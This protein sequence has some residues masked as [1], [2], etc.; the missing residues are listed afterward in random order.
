MKLD[1]NL[2]NDGRGKYAVVRLRRIDGAP[3]EL[4][5]ALDLLITG[6]FVTMDAPGGED[7]FFVIMLKDAYAQP[8]LVAY[9][10]A[11]LADGEIEYAGEVLDLAARSGRSHPLCKKP[12]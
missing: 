9:A 6:G 7:E 8:A 3:P 11:A 10:N 1:R 12:D 2:T 5:Q 4:K